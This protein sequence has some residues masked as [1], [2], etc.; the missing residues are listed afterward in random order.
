M[1]KLKSECILK[2]NLFI[3]LKFYVFDVTFYIF[4]SLPSQ[5]IIVV[6]NFFLLLLSSNLFCFKSGESTTFTVYLPL[7]LSLTLVSLYLFSCYYLAPIVFSL[8]KALHM[9]VCVCRCVC[10]YSFFFFGKASLVLMKSFSFHC[11]ENYHSF[12][13][14]LQWPGRVFLVEKKFFSSTL[15]NFSLLES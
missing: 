4:S 10:V 3:P 12:S 2:L 5:L 1:I 7:P 9:F 14:E 8:K 13:L 6:G 11:L 15:N